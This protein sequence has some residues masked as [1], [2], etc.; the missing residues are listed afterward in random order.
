METVF[1]TPET[2]KQFLRINKARYHKYDELIIGLALCGFHRSAG[3]KDVLIGFKMKADSYNRLPSKGKANLSLIQ[4][5]VDKYKDDY[6]PIDVV[7]AFNS[8]ENISPKTSNGIAYQLK[9][10]GRGTTGDA[11]LSL[12]NYL[13]SVVPKKYAKVDAILLIIIE[14]VKTINLPRVKEKLSFNT[15]PFNGIMFFFVSEPRII[16]GELW[17]GQGM[18]K[19][20]LSE[21]G[22]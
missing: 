10:F 7:I 3:V 11:A 19:Y 20:E 14:G 6:T 1:F 13:N 22:L 18:N 16:I 9:R 5:I 15:F 17:P 12:A 4:N 21:L 2:I 8:I